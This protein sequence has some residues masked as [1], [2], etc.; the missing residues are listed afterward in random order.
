MSERERVSLTVYNSNFALI[1]EQ[2]TVDLGTGRV[3]LAYE[4]VT[5]HIQPA[6]VHIRS[7][8][9]DDGIAVLEQNYRY[10]LLTPEKLLEKYVG[11][12]LK[13][14]RENE[15]SGEDEIEDAELLSVEN[16][17]VL[18]IDGQIVTGGFSRFIFPELPENLLSKPTLV[19]LLDSTRPRQ[20]LEVSYLSQNLSWRADY[21][22]V[23]DE[24]DSRGDLSGWVTLDNQSGTSFTAAELKLVAGD[25]QRVVPA[26]PPMPMME[27]D[28]AEEAVPQSSP[29]SQEALFEYHLYGLER[30]TDL[31]DKEQKQV[32]LLE[33]HGITVKKKLVFRGADYHYRGRVDETPQK[34]KVSVLVS[35]DNS[36]SK[37]L[38]VPLPKGVVRVYKADT[39]G[40]QQFVGEDA[41]EHTPRDEEIEIKLGEAFDVVAERKQASFRVLG[42]CSSESDWELE[43][44]NHKDS[45]VRVEVIEPA[46]GDYEIVRSSHPPLKGDAQSF[47]FEVDVPER[48]AVKVSYR[49][50]V[51]WC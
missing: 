13:V 43:L 26:P 46:G 18:R 23:L 40:A 17:P 2:R 5:A 22:L 41:I 7:M 10:D 16:G 21:V 49:V 31:L 39:S 27:M 25:V 48:G 14:V 32:S 42:K 29:F 33:A 3:A 9:A 30:P 36:E 11:R 45:A 50:R 12:R 19:W 8:D 24:S 15:R 51:R 44:K 34:Q 37:G 1:R 28:M 6:T 4:D 35:I 38:G 20:K 47:T